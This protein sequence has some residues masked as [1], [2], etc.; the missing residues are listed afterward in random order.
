[1]RLFSFSVRFFPE[2]RFTPNRFFK[3]NFLAKIPMIIIFMDSKNSK[4]EKDWFKK[5]T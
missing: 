5:K 2:L 1:M 4:K 3:T